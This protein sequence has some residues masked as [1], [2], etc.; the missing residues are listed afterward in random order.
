MVSFALSE[1]Q[2]AW[3][4]HVRE[5]ARTVVLPRTD[6]DLCN[7]FPRD[8]YEAAFDAKLVTA[9]LPA[10]LGG[11]G[12]SLFDVVLAGEELAYADLGVAASTFVMNL[13][14]APLLNFGTDEQKDRW[15]RPLCEKLGFT[16]YAWTEPEGSSNL[17]GRPASTIA[18]PVDGGFLISG[19]K[20]TISNGSVADVI[21]VFARIEPGP[22]GIS[23]FVLGADT[24]GVETSTPHQKMGQRA[25]DTADIVL[26]DVFVP[27]TDQIGLPGQGYQIAV[28]SML[29]SRTGIC[30]MA[31]GASRRAR[32]LVIDHGYA[33]ITADGKRL[34]DQQ[35]YRLRIAEMEAEIE[36]ARA[37]C[38]RAAWEVEHGSEAIKLSSCAKLIGGNV[39]VR[40]TNEAIEML[41]ATGY[42]QAG[43]AEKLFRDAKILQIY[44]GPQ[45]VQKM[46]I[47]DTATRRGKIG[48]S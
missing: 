13:G 2:E 18:R 11:G 19:A 25:A 36:M 8:L 5:F 3:R 43:L 48:Q 35:D 21:T 46:M 22:G 30:A 15:L 10:D 14:A 41:G 23:C 28:R 33:R 6:L 29:R 34:I 32:D 7:H 37:L 38:W 16:A 24:P 27:T 12:R 44:E 31:I 40:I 39:A 47:A 45:F 26:R 20:S 17:F 9:G 1:E 4:D 42:L